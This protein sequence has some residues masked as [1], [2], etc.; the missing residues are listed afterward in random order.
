MSPEAMTVE[1][2]APV[3]AAPKAMR[4]PGPLVIEI[5]D[6]TKVYEM[7]SETIHALRGVSLSIRRNEYP[8]HHGTERQRQ[9]HHDEHARLPGY[10]DRGE[11]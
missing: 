6:V 7:G 1:E 5:E 3:V 4:T 2:S 9:I 10:P 8:R 11:I